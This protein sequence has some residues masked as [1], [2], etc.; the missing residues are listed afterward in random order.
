MMRIDPRGLPTTLALACAAVL[1]GCAPATHYP[2]PS[3]KLLAREEKA[4][5]VMPVAG[6]VHVKTIDGRDVIGERLFP[7]EHRYWL[8]PGIHNVVIYY[9][10]GNSRSVHDAEATFVVE[11]GHRYEIR[12]WP[13][14]V[15]DLTTRKPVH[16][17]LLVAK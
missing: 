5:L 2:D 1:A 3:L 12:D 10:T 8:R 4:Q 7:Q 15:K 11:P 17:R 14:K 6:G 13:P 9:R 16:A